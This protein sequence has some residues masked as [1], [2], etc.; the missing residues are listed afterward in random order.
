[1]QVNVLWQNPSGNTIQVKMFNSI[2]QLLT[3]KTIPTNGKDEL[4]NIATQ[5]LPG[6][7][8]ILQAENDKGIKITKKIIK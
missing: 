3:S 2:G 5:T 1:M 6:G 4:I 8:Y 7:I